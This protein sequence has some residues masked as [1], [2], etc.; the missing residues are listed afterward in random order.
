[1]S[2][3]ADVTAMLRRHYLPENRPVAGIFAPEI[4]SPCGKR[5]ADLIW[6]P[7][8][9]AGGR[10]LHGHEIKVSRADVLAELADATKADPWAR[11]CNRWWLVVAHPSLIAGLDVPD[12]WGVM[13]PPSGRRT[14]SMTIVKPAPALTPEEP[15]PGIAR[16]AAWHLYTTQT[17]IG[18][19]TREVDWRERAL[20]Q[21]RRELDEARATGGAHVDGRAAMVA[22]II[23]VVEQRLRNE[24][25][26]SRLTDEVV[27]A[28]IVDHST[29]TD[30]ARSVARE[31][32]SL[33]QHVMSVVE[34]F[35]YSLREV[36]RA[37]KVAARLAKPELIL[38]AAAGAA[39]TAARTG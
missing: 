4:G 31:I 38:E 21:A 11:Y 29:V 26:W 37:D 25:V 7:T 6:M 30:A 35:R 9:I 15:S 20:Q 5:R 24:D 36:E 2:T 8:T 10:G 16:L 18:G 23:A 28:A 19:L 3:A 17:M 27:I 1:V 34:P 33:V 12:A 32:H 13:A 22:R 14:R 39:P